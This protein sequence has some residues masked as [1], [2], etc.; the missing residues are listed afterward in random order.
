MTDT[1]D[2]AGRANGKQVW[3]EKPLCKHSM[4]S[5]CSIPHGRRPL[6]GL[7]STEPISGSSDVFDTDGRHRC[8]QTR[9]S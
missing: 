5:I 1:V 6:A 4:P 9:P 3:T 8:W 2:A 7:C